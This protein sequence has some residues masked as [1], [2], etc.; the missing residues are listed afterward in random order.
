MP[1][2]PPPETIQ[3]HKGDD[4]EKYGETTICAEVGCYANFNSEPSNYTYSI[5]GST[6][7]MDGTGGVGFAILNDKGELIGFS[8]KKTFEISAEA[9]AA[10]ASGKAS[11]VTLKA[12]NTPVAA[13]NVMDTGNT[14]EKYALL[15]ELLGNAKQLLDLSDETGTKVG[16]YRASSLT[17]LQE[18]YGSA[19]AVYDAQTIA[20]YSAVYDVLY[21]DMQT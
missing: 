9:T 13:T 18:A 6:V 16:Y 15:G 21:Q 12:D 17:K 20:A 10:I 4:L 2:G 5:S 3:S 1:P 14:E 19:K 11:I 8:D 7:T